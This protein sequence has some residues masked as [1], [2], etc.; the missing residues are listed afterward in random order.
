MLQYLLDYSRV[1][2]ARDDFHFATTL[3]TSLNLHRMAAPLNTRFNRRDQDMPYCFD[4]GFDPGLD[5][6]SACAGF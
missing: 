4:P 6:A 2:N 1:F 3:S 5:S